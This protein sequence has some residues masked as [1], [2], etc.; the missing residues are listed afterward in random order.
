MTARAANAI[1]GTI[2]S[3]EKVTSSQEDSAISV[4]WSGDIKNTTLVGNMPQ[5]E[6]QAHV[7]EI[8]TTRV[9]HQPESMD[10]GCLRLPNMR[11]YISNERVRLARACRVQEPA[12]GLDW[13]VDDTPKKFP[14]DAVD[15]KAIY[16][17]VDAMPQRLP[18]DPLDIT[19]V[20]WSAGGAPIASPNRLA[21][22]CRV[23]RGMRRVPALAGALVGCLLR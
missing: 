10:W 6:V 15:I 2:K 23:M 16:W 18:S 7:R 9:I 19:P 8:R 12:R 17:G 4:D 13:G 14:A 3:D 5:P 20:D 1:N 22:L 11:P 21:F